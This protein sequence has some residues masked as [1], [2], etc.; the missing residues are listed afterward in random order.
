MGIVTL[1]TLVYR[2]IGGVLTIFLVFVLF[3]S[4]RKS[5]QATSEF[6][7]LRMIFLWYLASMTLWILCQCTY[8]TFSFLITTA[9]S[10]YQT[11]I[12]IYLISTASNNITGYLT[13]DLGALF[14]YFKI[15]DVF[16]NTSLSVNST[17]FTIFLIISLLLSISV[18]IGMTMRQTSQFINYRWSNEVIIIT[19]ALPYLTATNIYFISG[20]IMYIRRIYKFRSLTTY[21]DKHLSSDI[22]QI[23]VML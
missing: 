22:N 18:S 6:D 10:K 11:I 9:V 4:F 8:D 7:K 2:L 12:T 15:K 5:Y 13:A 3:F 17:A 21:N 23:V 1:W 20:I 14:L 19:L 16:K